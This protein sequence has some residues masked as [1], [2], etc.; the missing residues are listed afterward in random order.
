M[1]IVSKLKE[2]SFANH[3]HYHYCQTSYMCIH[4]ILIFHKCEI[5]KF[6]CSHLNLSVDARAIGFRGKWFQSLVTKT[7]K[8]VSLLILGNCVIIEFLN[9]QF[10]ISAELVAIMTRRRVY[11][12]NTRIDGYS[13]PYLFLYIFFFFKLLRL[14][15]APVNVPHFYRASR[16]YDVLTVARCQGCDMHISA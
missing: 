3:S 16:L 10:E 6:I 1:T 12:C 8:S 14:P 15:V 9:R 2:N 4:I 13:F 5:F 11:S 7:Q